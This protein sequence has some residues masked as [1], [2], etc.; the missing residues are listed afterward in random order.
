MTCTRL[1][2]PTGQVRMEMMNRLGV[3]TVAVLLIL[4][5]WFL[6]LNEI[7]IVP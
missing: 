1:K 6:C 7:V 2:K 3:D 4:Q 5:P